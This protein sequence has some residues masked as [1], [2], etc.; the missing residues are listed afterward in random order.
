MNCDNNNNN[1]V[2][3]NK[4]WSI[5]TVCI[6]HHTYYETRGLYGGGIAP[7]LTDDGKPC[8]CDQ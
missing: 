4:G 5:D 3:V 2:K 6:E 7:K 1:K 8:H